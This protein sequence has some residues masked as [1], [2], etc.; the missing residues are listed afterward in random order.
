MKPKSISTIFDIGG[1]WIGPGYWAISFVHGHEEA[2]YVAGVY[3]VTLDD[4]GALRSQKEFSPFPARAYDWTDACG[5]DRSGRA[6]FTSVRS[7]AAKRSHSPGEAEKIVAWHKRVARKFSAW[8]TVTAFFIENDDCLCDAKQPLTKLAR[9]FEEY[10]QNNPKK[11]KHPFYAGLNPEIAAQ[12]I[13]HHLGPVGFLLTANELGAELAQGG[14]DSVPVQIV[15]DPARVLKKADSYRQKTKRLAKAPFRFLVHS[16]YSRYDSIGY[17]EIPGAVPFA[18]PIEIDRLPDYLKNPVANTPFLLPRHLLLP[19]DAGVSID[20]I[21]YAGRR[22]HPGGMVEKR[23]GVLEQENEERAN[24]I[25]FFHPQ[26]L[27]ELGVA[28]HEGR[29]RDSLLDIQ[30]SWTKAAGSKSDAS[31]RFFGEDREAVNSLDIRDPEDL[32]L[33]GKRLESAKRNPARFPAPPVPISPARFGSP[34]ETNPAMFPEGLLR[35]IRNYDASFLLAVIRKNPLSEISEPLEQLEKEFNKVLS[36]HIW[37]KGKS[38]PASLLKTLIGES[39]FNPKGRLNS[40]KRD[41]LEQTC[42]SLQTAFSRMLASFAPRC[43]LENMGILTMLGN[44]PYP[45]AVWTEKWIFDNFKK[46]AR[47]HGP[48]IFREIRAQSNSPRDGRLVEFDEA[49]NYSS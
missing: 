19:R 43:A 35:A 22:S 49:K 34:M 28:Y 44:P 3:G 17:G 6:F 23:P 2:R 9:A 1:L 31:C 4:R 47:S 21:L 29:L 33:F 46:F 42:L 12:C 15:T 37:R 41:A 8:F 40:E 18:P 10:S 11:A 13:R 25:V 32:Q 7:A 27:A 5:A 45:V 36:S 26:L 24:L 14:K 30:A 48:R 16:T 20:E 38:D 39:I